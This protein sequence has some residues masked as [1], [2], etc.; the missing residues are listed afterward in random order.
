[1]SKENSTNPEATQKQIDGQLVE[2]DDAWFA[3]E[4]EKSVAALGEDVVAQIEEDARRELNA[5][6]IDLFEREQERL[7][8]YLHIYLM[9]SKYKTGLVRAAAEKFVSSEM[10]QLNRSLFFLALEHVKNIEKSNTW[11][12]RVFMKKSLVT[13]PTAEEIV[14]TWMEAY[15]VNDPL[16]ERVFNI[17]DATF[18]NTAFS[19]IL[20]L[21]N[22]SSRQDETYIEVDDEVANALG[23]SDNV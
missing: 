22:L 21:S 3:A 7:V 15:R 8:E 23:V 2:I 17:I 4:R 20:K 10:A 11:F 18:S 5:P 14:A 1:M 13:V 9:T 16:N 19:E 6:D 12:K